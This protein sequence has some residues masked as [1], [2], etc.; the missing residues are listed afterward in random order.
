[1]DYGPDI[2][3][4]AFQNIYAGTGKIYVFGVNAKQ[5]IFNLTFEQQVAI[6]EEI[7]FT[8]NVCF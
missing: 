4:G 8:L 7:I 6:N 1:M 5:S 2:A 3:Q